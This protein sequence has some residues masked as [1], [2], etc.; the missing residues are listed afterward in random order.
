MKMLVET[1]I[2]EIKRLREEKTK[3][4]RDKQLLGQQV[5]QL[6]ISNMQKDVVI[7]QLGQQVASVKIQL[8]QI[9]K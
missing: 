9:Q 5:A 1:P 8:M 3:L 6:K 4:E 2:S 7:G